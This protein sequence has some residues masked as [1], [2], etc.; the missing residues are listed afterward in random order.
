MTADVRKSYRTKRG[1]RVVA[2]NIVSAE[3]RFGS[4]GWILCLA[5]GN[6]FGQPR[7]LRAVIG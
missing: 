2:D 3:H 7:T 5:A 4:V 6:T 1:M